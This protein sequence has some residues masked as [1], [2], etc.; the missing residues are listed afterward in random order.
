MGIEFSESGSR[1]FFYGI[2]VMSAFNAGLGANQLRRNKYIGRFFV[3]ISFLILF[4]PLGMRTVGIDHDIYME[5]YNHADFWLKANYYLSPEP[6]FAGL[7]ILAKDVIGDFQI[8]YLFSAFVYLAGVFAF[9]R[10]YECYGYLSVFFM[11]FSLYLYMCGLARISIAIGIS[12]YAFTKL[13]GK[14]KPLL[15][16]L[17]ATLFHYTAI[18][19]VLVYLSNK[20]KRNVSLKNVIYILASFVALSYVITVFSSSLPYVI[21]RYAQYVK[22]SFNI[23][24]ISSV[25][26]LLPA[27]V[28]WS[29]YK[30]GYKSIYEE[31]YVFF[32]NIVKI[33]FALMVLSM[34]YDGV[35]RITFFFYPFAAKIYYDFRKILWMTRQ[36]VVVP[37]YSGLFTIIGLVYV[38]AVYFTS[39]FI[40]PY[41]VPFA[42]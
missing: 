24:Y 21:Y 20:S 15:L 30:S 25:I 16:I 42:M 18:I 40:T 3:I 34:M 39:P 5:W 11:S 7:T 33:I 4:I 38:Y 1:L 41:I 35:F 28:L 12:S 29:L 9:L 2:F 27:I 26:V 6:L 14:V 22:F 23:R 8:I 19:T 32:D 36:E 13:D 37:I 17:L 31:K 10:K